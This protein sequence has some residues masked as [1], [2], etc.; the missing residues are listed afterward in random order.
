M[1]ANITITIRSMNL[2]I[3]F[4]TTSINLVV[5]DRSNHSC[6]YKTSG[7]PDSYLSLPDI[8]QKEQDVDK[9]MKTV[10]DLIRGI[11]EQIKRKSIYSLIYK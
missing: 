2:G 9:I 11:P 1:L 5:L 4:G 6:T 10:L 8:K 7:M 3:D